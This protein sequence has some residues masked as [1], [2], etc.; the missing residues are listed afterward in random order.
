MG[1]RDVDKSKV[2]GLENQL[3]R[4]YPKHP[5]H[6]WRPVAEVMHWVREVSLAEGWRPPAQ[7]QETARRTIWASAGAGYIY[8][9]GDKSTDMI[10]MHELAHSRSSLEATRIGLDQPRHGPLWRQIFLD[11]IPDSQIRTALRHKFNEQS[12]P[13]GL[14]A[15][16]ARQDR[17][18]QAQWDRDAAAR[19][20]EGTTGI[21]FV[22]R[23]SKPDGSYVDY[24]GGDNWGWSVG[25]I[26]N[27][28][29][30][31]RRSTAEKRIRPGSHLTYEVIEV[32][33]VYRYGK[34]IVAL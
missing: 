7:Y 26:R 20:R 11:L 4:E 30:A 5:L 17:L 28:K 12:M 19:R 31:R 29:V 25:R 34:W 32:P 18:L 23:R 1:L 27:A 22:V 15:E 16:Q 3:R 10:G 8:Y 33:V 21:G 6:V 13:I 24:L 14:R 2:Y 9:Y